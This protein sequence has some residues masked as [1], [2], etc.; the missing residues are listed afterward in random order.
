MLGDIRQDPDDGNGVFP[1]RVRW[2]G[3]NNIDLPWVSNPATQADFQ[4]MPAEGGPVVSIM[5]REVGTIYQA[6]MISRAS[7]RGPPAI[8]DIV[9]V[10]DKRGSIARDAVVDIG[11]YQFFIAEDGFFLWNGTNATPIGDGR[12]NRYFFS[13][14]AYAKRSRIVGAVDYVNGCVMWAF[15]TD[16]TGALTEIIIYSYRENKW[17]HSIQVLEYLFSS[18]LSNVTVEELTLPIEQYVDTFDSDIYRLGG[19]AR[20]AAFSSVHAYGLFNGAPMAATLDT[21]E[22]S[23]PNGSRPPGSVGRG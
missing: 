9:P 23:G 13:K 21:G 16:S 4:D 10:E 20:L 22:Y 7:Y 14:L 8:F 18:A 12:V 3:F 11:A 6:R 2:G 15:P 1:A 19:R 5:G 17:S